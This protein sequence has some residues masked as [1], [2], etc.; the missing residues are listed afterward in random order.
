LILQKIYDKIIIQKVLRILKWTKKAPM[1]V[2]A[3]LLNVL[4]HS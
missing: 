2:G 4:E 3:F 1:P